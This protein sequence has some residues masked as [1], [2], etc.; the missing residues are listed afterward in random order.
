[1]FKVI[2]ILFSPFLMRIFFFAVGVYILKLSFMHSV[3][4]DAVFFSDKHFMQKYD[5][6]FND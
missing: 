2:E 1:M 5:T 3:T 4:M 6:F